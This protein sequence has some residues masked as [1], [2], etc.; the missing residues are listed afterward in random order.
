MIYRK[1]TADD[2]EQ[3]WNQNIQDNP[4]N[5]QWKAWKAEYV[6]INENNFGLTYIAVDNGRAIGEGT[7]LFSPKCSAIRGRT[8]LADN[9][10]VANVNALRMQKAYEGKGY[11]SRL[12]KLME[13]E[14]VA[15]GYDRLTIGV[16]ANQT[17]NLAIYLHWG[18]T[19]FL[20]AEEEDGELVLYYQKA[21]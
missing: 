8:R 13:R 19:E 1:A 5:D 20:F 11:M 4:E 14:A 6:G 3:V 18:F 9:A 10:A 2:L 21:L 17:R 7:L 12:V 15:M 16:E